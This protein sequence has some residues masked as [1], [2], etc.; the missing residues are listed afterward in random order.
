MRVLDT[1]QDIFKNWTYET[2]CNDC[3]SRLEVSALD[4]KAVSDPRDGDYAV[5]KCPV[6]KRDIT[7]D[8]SLIPRSVW[9]R[10]KG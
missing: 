8:S 1:R 7:L 2:T 4:L 5:C 6:C 3:E 9:V 10:L